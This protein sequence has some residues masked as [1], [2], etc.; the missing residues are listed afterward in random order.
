[1]PELKA[2]AKSYSCG[3]LLYTICSSAAV[4]C[5]SSPKLADGII[6]AEWR[7]GA[8]GLTYTRRRWNIA[9][10]CQFIAA[11]IFTGESEN[12]ETN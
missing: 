9:L 12:H 3:L 8:R 11:A 4:S 6:I 1:M 5:L 7:A 2:A 10:Y